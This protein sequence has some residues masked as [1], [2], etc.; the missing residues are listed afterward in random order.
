[1]IDRTSAQEALADFFRARR[2]ADLRS[3]LRA[4][5]RRDDALLN[6]DEVRRRLR[7]V[8][9]SLPRLEDVPLDAIVGS[10]GRYNDFTREFLPKVDGGKER[11]VGIR[12]AMGGMSGTPP[13]ELYRIGDAYFV[14]DGNHRVSVA[15]QLG[16]PTIQAFVTPVRSRVPLAPSATPDDLILAEELARFLEETGLD[17]VRPGADVRLTAPGGYDALREHIA[18]HRYFMGIERQGDVA[19]DEAVAHWYDVVYASV[20][21]AIRASGVLRDFPGRTEA[22][23][24]LWLSD[25]RGRL[26]GEFGFELPSESI[27]EHLAGAPVQDDQERS[28]ILESVRRHRRDATAPGASLVE[29]V[30]VLVEEGAWST[31]EQGLEIARRE[32]ARL[33]GLHVEGRDTETG[34]AEALAARFADACSEAGVPGQFTRAIGSLG[35]HVGERLPWFD[36]AVLPLATRGVRGGRRLDAE[37]ATILRRSP[38]PVLATPRRVSR[39]EAALIA[40]DGGRK[41]EEALFAAAYLGAKWDT[42]LVVVTVDDLATTGAATLDQARATLER[43]DLRADYVLASGAVADEL[44]STAWERGCDLIILG[45]SRA[46]RVVDAV[47][48]GTLVKTLVAAPVPVLVV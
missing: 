32:G 31:V 45:R 37:L 22:D 40:Y 9:G 35:V 26:A 1:V 7:A 21:A 12:V 16:A 46:A 27:A 41:A 39:F 23:L 2:R 13:V 14:R 3:L 38:R 43:F 8:E 29:D 34:G 4:V 20:V 47:V 28:E 6:Y 36:L 15:R 42:R 44:H 10:V 25:H 33:Y 19:E 17:L 30:L 18:V 11:W 48:G 5:V 24:Y